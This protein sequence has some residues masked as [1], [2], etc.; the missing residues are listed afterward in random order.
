MGFK[1]ISNYGKILENLVAIELRKKEVEDVNT[2]IYYW[3]NQQHEEVDFV[4]KNGL[5]VEQLIQVCWNI[6][7]YKTKEREI[8][9]LLKASDELKCDN[10]L[11]V[12]QDKEGKE[13]IKNKEI[14]Y[15]SLATWLLKIKHNSKF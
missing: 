9:A 5:N 10:L 6:N 2:E 7:D 3:H 11:I 8:K 1:F 15:I 13:T 14:N 4:I 12:N